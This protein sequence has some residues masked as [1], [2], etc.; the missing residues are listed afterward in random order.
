LVARLREVEAKIAALRDTV[1]RDARI[2]GATCTKAYLSQKDIGQVDLTII[3]EASMVILP[4]VWFSAGLSRERVVISGDFHQIPPILPTQQEAVFEVL[5]RDVF[6]AAEVKDP[7]GRRLMMLSTQYRM[8]SEIC[9]LI[10][11]PMYER[12]L[13]TYAGRKSI[14]GRLPPEPFEKPLTI[15]DTSDLW[16]FETQNIFFSRF[17]MLHALLARNLAWHLRREGVIES[18]SD[19]GICTP[20]AAQSRMIQKL[21]EGEELDRFVPVGTVHRYQGDERRIMLLDIPESHGGSWALGQFVQG[22]PP[23]HI[24][25]RLINVAV[26]RAQEHLMVLANLTYLDRRLPSTALLRGILYD[27]QEKGRVVP[28]RDV[29][30]LRPIQSDLSGL[31][32]QMPFDEITESLGIFN[33]AQ[34]ERALLHDIQTAKQSVVLFSGYVTLTRVGKLGD[35]LR[36]K[37]ASGVKVRC[38]TR[39]PKLNGSIPENAGR[40]AIEMLEGIGAVVDCRSKIHQKVCLIDN[41]IVWWGSLNALSHMYHSDETMTRAVNEG[42][43]SLVAAHMSKRPISAEKA[44]A[45]VGEAE[46]PRCPSC[47]KRTVLDEGRYGPFF[48]CEAS[49][50]WRQSVRSETQRTRTRG[51]AGANGHDAHSPQK[52]PPCPE[53]GGETLQRQGKYG[54]FYGCV[55][56]PDCKGIVRMPRATAVNT[57][58]R[59]SRSQRS[60]SRNRS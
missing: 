19:F 27:M 48:Y 35:L 3:D 26:S 51:Q 9:E 44:I 38:V 54:A 1:L 34:F 15:I 20:Y 10:A 24:G 7:D 30:R 14:P 13:V 45:T 8:R 17:N 39:P 37:I 53:C 18:K 33:E 4:V 6:N 16:P 57:P 56:Y 60:R 22:L 59:S 58:N 2:V 23:E 50:G 28:G 41:R 47:G 31:I 52:G 29:L 49:C 11:G 32:G 5:G 40:E 43:A 36:S 12:R 25:A 42:F 46:N 55:R 21:V